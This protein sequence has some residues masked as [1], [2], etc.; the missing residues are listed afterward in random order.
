MGKE[1]VG[2]GAETAGNSSARKRLFRVVIEVHG[3]ADLFHV[4]DALCAPGG[5][6]GGLHGRQQERDQNTDDRDHDK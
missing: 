4:A 6:A 2:P 1:F 5:F 3:D